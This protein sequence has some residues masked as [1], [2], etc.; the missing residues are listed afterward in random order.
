MDNYRVVIPSTSSLGWAYVLVLDF[1]STR[2]E[3]GLHSRC[4][5]SRGD[6]WAPGEGFVDAC[7][8]SGGGSGGLPPCTETALTL[9]RVFAQFLQSL[10]ELDL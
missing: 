2:M 6:H 10:Q 5:M 7:L 8:C 3:L 4:M 1:N 9:T